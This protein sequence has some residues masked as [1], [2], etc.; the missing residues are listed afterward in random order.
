MKRF[1]LAAR[2]G[3]KVGLMSVILL[4]LLSIVGYLMLGQ[5]LERTAQS[6]L[7]T[8]MGGMAHNLSTVADLSEVTADSHQLVDLAMGHNNLF[9][10]IFDTANSRIPLLTIGSKKITT[11]LTSF[12]ANDQVEFYE[13]NNELG[14]PMLSVSQLM[15]LAD[16]TQVGVYMT[17]DE[18]SDAELLRA[19]LSWALMPSP[20]ILAL[21]MVVAWWT[22]RRGLLPLTRFLKVASK[23]S[24][25]N[26]QH[27]LPTDRLPIELLELADGINFMLHRLDGGVQQLSQFS[28]D[29]S[30]ELRAP[31]TNLMGK[32]Q[33][34]LSRPRSSEEYREV[35]E[36]CAEELDRMKSMVADMLFLAHV[37]Q[38]AALVQFETVALV[39]EV[40]RVSD[41]FSLSA[42]ESGVRL[43]VSGSVDV[44]QGNR[45][46]IQRA[47]SNLLSNAIRYCPQGQ[48]VVVK[49]H[50]EQEHIRLSVGN[51]G[52]G[53]PE[54]HLP[55]LFERFYRVDKGRARSEGGTGLGLAIVRSIMSLHQGVA[56][57]EITGSGFTWFH[58][59]FPVN[60][61]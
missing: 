31:L 18:S 8:K 43:D 35:L 59:S 36:S 50:R 24:T 11:E 17:V 54:E 42:E 14:M 57:V 27:R 58:L 1:S 52:Q 53:I 47:V 30:H 32:A 10:S 37:S 21:I 25:D 33:V 45:L 28:D 23:I 20:F 3:L 46:M 49:V 39:D 12:P 55:H 61:L 26:M 9:V 7:I 29:L 2:L 22:V 51:P 15:R 48:A 44:I 19:M 13:W 40:Q 4:V 41:L 5:A 16:G 34:A 56:K 38:P 6:S 60:R